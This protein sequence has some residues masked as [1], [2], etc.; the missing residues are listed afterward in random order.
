MKINKNEIV[1]KVLD[2][3]AKK[4]LLGETFPEM[5]SNRIDALS[6]SII[7]ELKDFLPDHPEQV[8]EIVSWNLEQ[9]L[10]HW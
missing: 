10:T 5:T 4:Q 3:I 7:H 1:Q 2:L 9:N 8:D 6:D